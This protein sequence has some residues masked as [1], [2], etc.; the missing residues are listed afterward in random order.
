[1]RPPLCALCVGLGA[2]QL[3]EAFSGAS[4][5]SRRTPAPA[6]GGAAPTATSSWSKNKSWYT[7]TG[8]G[9]TSAAAV[10]V[11]PAV[12]AIPVRPRTALGAAKVAVDVG[13]VRRGLSTARDR[14]DK[15]RKLFDEARLAGE[16]EYLE[17]VSSEADFWNDANAARKTLGDLNRCVCSVQCAVARVDGMG[18]VVGWRWSHLTFCSVLGSVGCNSGF[19]FAL[20]AV[21]NMNHRPLRSRRMR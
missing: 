14:L 10:V 9:A 18:W 19:V 7:T 20:G 21:N 17:G 16:L 8:G 12:E 11:A 4:I 6:A 15:N 5:W 3:A 13:D 2:I 1:M